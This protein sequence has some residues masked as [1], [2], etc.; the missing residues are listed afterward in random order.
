MEMPEQYEQLEN[1]PEAVDKA[2]LEQKLQEADEARGTFRSYDMNRNGEIRTTSSGS[3]SLYQ[4][5]QATF[6]GRDGDVQ[7]V[8]TARYSVEMGEAKLYPD[9]FQAPDTQTETALLS[10][11]SEQARAQGADKLTVWVND[12]G[13]DPDRWLRRGFQPTE[14]DP[15]AKGVFW[16]K[17][18]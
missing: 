3:D 12:E 16:Q 5:A 14:R 6:Y 11:V 17:Q 9:R 15:D 1:N 13:G 4:E 10:E 18:L 2:D 7:T 8:G